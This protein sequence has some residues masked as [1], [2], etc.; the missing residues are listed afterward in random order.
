MLVAEDMGELENNRRFMQGR[1]AGRFD[2]GADLDSDLHWL[3]DPQERKHDGKIQE[4]SFKEIDPLYV[5]G[6]EVGYEEGPQ[7]KKG[8][9]K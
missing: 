7:V 9:K 3:T 2:K 1:E 5:Q 4:I 8:K 6:Y